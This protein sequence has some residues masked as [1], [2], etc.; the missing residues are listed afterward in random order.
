MTS[1]PDAEPTDA[2]PPE[3]AKIQDEWRKLERE[4]IEDELAE[5]REDA[6][7][8]SPGRRRSSWLMWLA[9]AVALVGGIVAAA[10]LNVPG[11]R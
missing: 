10:L 9:F 2:T 8:G 5:A 4:R 6:L 1:M 11:G 7:A 3:D